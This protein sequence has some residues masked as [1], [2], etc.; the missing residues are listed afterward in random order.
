MGREKEHPHPRGP[1]STTGGTRVLPGDFASCGF[2]NESGVLC[3]DLVFYTSSSCVRENGERAFRLLVV[4]RRATQSKAGK[5][6]ADARTVVSC[7][8]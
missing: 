1:P 4:G 2:H 6:G 8:S 5:D 3:P 7:E